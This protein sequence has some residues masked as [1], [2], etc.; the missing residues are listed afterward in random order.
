MAELDKSLLED[1]DDDTTL[2]KSLRKQL[3]DAHKER[4]ELQ[5]AVSELKG[6]DRVRS[7]SEILKSKGVSEKVAKLLPSDIDPSED[8]IGAWLEEF[9]DVIGFKVV[10][11]GAKPDADDE[12]VSAYRDLA[13][14]MD[15]M[16][17]PN[18]GL[19]AYHQQIQNAKTPEEAHA[20]LAAAAQ[21]AGLS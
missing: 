14:A 20:A 5:T 4:T 1:T 8:A 19:A 21:L 11:E 10:D 2:V 16:N 13:S 17:T 3:R 6:K 9:K 7:V 12:T 18:A 15:S